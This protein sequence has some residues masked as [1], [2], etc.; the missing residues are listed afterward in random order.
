MLYFYK[1]IS[2]HPIENLHTYLHF[3]FTQLFAEASPTYDHAIHIHADFKATIDKNK[4]QVDD[5]LNAIFSAYMALQPIEKQSV[6][7]AYENNNNLTGI[8]NIK[9]VPGHVTFGPI[10][11]G[12]IIGLTSNC[13]IPDVSD[14]HCELIIHLK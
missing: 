11:T 12:F 1:S 5:K 3:F 4:V 6:K 7:D 8:C 13:V 2:P 10:I 14:P 9:V